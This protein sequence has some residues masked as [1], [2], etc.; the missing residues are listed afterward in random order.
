MCEQAVADHVNY[1][2]KYGEAHDWVKA[3]KKS[4]DDVS[5]SILAANQEQL[6]NLS[7]QLQNLVGLK[8]K[9]T[10]MLN[11]LQDLVEKAC[12]STAIDG[13]ELIRTQFE[14]LQQLFESTFDSISDLDRDLKVR[15]S[16]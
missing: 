6:P 7:E 2:G 13:R 16:R 3:R 10:L 5:A 14:E 9:G 4:L 12:S 11:A 15:I 1:N 8:P